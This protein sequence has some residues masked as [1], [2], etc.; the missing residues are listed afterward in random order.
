MLT[1]KS[2]IEVIERS[3]KQVSILFSDIEH[4]TRHWGRRGD[5]DARILLDRHNRLLF[6][7][8]R[9]Y[10][11]RIIKTL[12]D[13][14]MAAFTHADD[15][16]QAAIAIQQMLSQERER[17]P[18]F[19]LR[20]RIGIHTGKGLIELDDIFGDVVNVAAKVESS[21]EANEILITQSCQARLKKHYALQ[22]HNS[23]KLAGKIKD[24]SLFSCDWSTHPTLTGAIRAHSIIPL[25]TRH[26]LEILS[27]VAASLF[28]LFFLYQYYFRFLMSD[29][30]INFNSLILSTYLPSDYPTVLILQTLAMVIFSLYL[31]RIH[32]I[33]R[34]LLKLLNGCFAASLI[35]LSFAAINHYFEFPFKKR[36]YDPLYESQQ[37]FVQVLKNNTQVNKEPDRKSELLHLAPRGEIYIYQGSKTI[38]NLRWDRVSYSDTQSG[39]LPRRILPAFGVAEEQLTRT[40]KFYFR[41]YDLYGLIL[42]IMAFIW[43]YTDYKIRPS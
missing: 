4:S 3:R 10:H 9:K 28:T 36:W 22:P 39:W 38:D 33:S 23:L 16:L 14:I 5:I 17:D 19:S 12:G 26:K 43:G 30:G 15:A 41:Y 20:S 18:F 13:S 34:H 37:L 40:H 21:A 8:I 25:L 7:V 27:Y 32:F 2:T 11:G 31:L 24:I 29:Y 35:I 1:D 42:A 6:P